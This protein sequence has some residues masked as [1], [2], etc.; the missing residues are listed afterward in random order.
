MMRFAWA[1]YRT[2]AWGQDELRPVSKTARNW[3]GPS[4]LAASIV[5]ALDTLW[6]MGLEDEYK[7]AAEFVRNDLSFDKD[8][9]V[10]FFETVIRDL[11]G[12]LAAYGLTGDRA[13][14]DKA[15]DLGARLLAAFRSPTGLPYGVVNLRTGTASPQSWSGNS[16]ILAE[17]GTFQLEFRYLSHVTGKSKYAELADRVSNYVYA[18][19]A[20]YPGLYPNNL[21]VGGG[22]GGLEEYSFGGLGDSYYEYL[23][24]QWIFTGR[25]EAKYL[26]QYNRAITVRGRAPGGARRPSRSWTEGRVRQGW[27]GRRHQHPHAPPPPKKKTQS[28]QQHMIGRTGGSRPRTWV[29]KLSNGMREPSMEHL[30]SAHAKLS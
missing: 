10:S 12:L 14:V 16:H 30:V 2:Y 29:G 6:V 21:P 22:R 5:D 17:V 7:E 24:K 15:D 11:G 4:G 9:T 25:T 18:L 3:L 23:L 26:D 28:C 8:V 1:G 19:P 13:F 27:G 20:T